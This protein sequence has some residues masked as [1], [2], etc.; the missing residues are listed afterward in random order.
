[1][2]PP[3]GERFLELPARVKNMASVCDD[4]VYVVGIEFIDANG[5]RWWRDERGALH[6]R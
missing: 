3:G 5:Q 2:I 4:K 1:M 6:D